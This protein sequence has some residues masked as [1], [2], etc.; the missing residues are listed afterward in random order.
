MYLVGKERGQWY[1][2]SFNYNG[3]DHAYDANVSNIIYPFRPIL[4]LQFMSS[5][6]GNS[7]VESYNVSF[8]FDITFKGQRNLSSA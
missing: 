4:M 5:N 6:L 1:G 7:A 8:D 2:A 3:M